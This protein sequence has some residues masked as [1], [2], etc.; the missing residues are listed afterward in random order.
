MEAISQITFGFPGLLRRK[1]EEDENVE[2]QA[3]TGAE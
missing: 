3:R 2:N 1:D